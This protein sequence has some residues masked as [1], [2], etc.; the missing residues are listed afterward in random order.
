VLADSA[1]SSKFSL[2]FPEEHQER[3]T[4]DRLFGS[5]VTSVD[6]GRFALNDNVQLAF[7]YLLSDGRSGVAIAAWHGAR[8]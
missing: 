2:T 4:R 6:L 7:H 8:P 5:T 1:H 3:G